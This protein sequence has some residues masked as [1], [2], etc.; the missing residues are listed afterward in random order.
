MHLPVL[1][2]SCGAGDQSSFQ[3]QSSQ[4]E[5]FARTCLSSA[6]VPKPPSGILQSR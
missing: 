5:L 3:R 2:R 4:S 6:E 1:L